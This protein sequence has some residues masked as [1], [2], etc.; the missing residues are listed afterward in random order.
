MFTIFHSYPKDLFRYLASNHFAAIQP[1]EIKILHEAKNYLSTDSAKFLGVELRI[2]ELQNKLVNVR[3]G[4]QHNKEF[5]KLTKN[6]LQLAH[7]KKARKLNNHVCAQFRDSSWWLELQVVTPHHLRRPLEKERQSWQYSGEYASFSTP[8]LVRAYR[9]TIPVFKNWVVWANLELQAKRKEISED[10]AEEY[11]NYLDQMINDI[12][13]EQEKI[14]SSFIARIRAG[15]QQHDLRF[16]DIAQA[17]LDVIKQANSPISIPDMKTPRRTMTPMSMQTIQQIIFEDGTESEKR[18]LDN[19][20]FVKKHKAKED[21]RLAVRMDNMG[22]PFRIPRGMEYQMPVKPPFYLKLPSF[23]HLLFKGSRTRY[24]FFQDSMCQFV[25]ALKQTWEEDKS[26]S[27]ENFEH[28]L[29]CIHSE[30][31]RCRNANDQ[32]SKWAHAEARGMVSQYRESLEKFAAKVS[33]QKT[34]AAVKVTPIEINFELA[35]QLAK[36]L[37]NGELISRDELFIIVAAKNQLLKQ[38]GIADQAKLNFIVSSDQLMDALP[39]RLKEE[40]DKDPSSITG[41]DLILHIR[42]LKS[43]YLANSTFNLDYITTAEFQRNVFDYT[44]RLVRGIYALQSSSQYLQKVADIE[45]VSSWLAEISNNNIVLL[46]TLGCISNIKNK[47][48]TLDW[49]LVRDY[50]IAL[51]MKPLESSVNSVKQKTAN[52]TEQTHL[53]ASASIHAFFNGSAVSGSDAS[54]AANRA[55]STNASGASLAAHRPNTPGGN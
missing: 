20:L 22:Y 36:K 23:L 4:S 16:D 1:E 17:S 7:V 6:I 51:I 44:Y 29:D 43:L 13:L 37:T 31:E 27:V 3:K 50:E 48:Q 5:F 54:L 32:L 21:K 9:E 25:L 40:L 14:R 8:D 30:I 28:A 10:K 47:L 49:T 42:K 46:D 2:Q 41:Q 26:R 15:L 19:A 35:D 12:L 33:Q 53:S 55:N 11:Q 39:K 18:D 52:T 45:Y 34:E 24:E 38:G